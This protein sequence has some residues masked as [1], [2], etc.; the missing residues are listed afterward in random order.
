[1]AE[2]KH[3]PFLAISA[4]LMIS[5]AVAIDN[6][7]YEHPDQIG[8]N[9]QQIYTDV[10]ASVFGENRDSVLESLSSNISSSDGYA[11]LTEEQ[12][13]KTDIVSGIAVCRKYL[14][15]GECSKCVTEASKLIKAQCLNDSG[16]RIHLDGCFLRYENSSSFDWKDV[17]S[18]KAHFCASPNDS[19][20]Q[21]FSQRAEALSSQLISDAAANNSYAVG[22]SNDG[23]LYGLAQ[24]WPS[25]TTSSCQ[26]CLA[27]AQNLLLECLPQQEGR[28]LEAGCFMRYSTYEFYSDNQTSISTNP[29][30]PSGKSP[31]KRVYILLGS[32]GGSTALITAVCC[33]LLCRYIRHRNGYNRT[34]EK[35]IPKGNF[36]HGA[37]ENVPVLYDYEVLRQST[38]NF[39]RNNIL[40]KG[41][42]GEVYKGTL[43]DGTDVAVKKLN[44]RQDTTQGAE[45]FLREVKFL[46]SVRHRNLVRLRGC[47]TSGSERLLVYEFMSNNG[48][49]KH[50]FGQITNSLNWE[51]RLDIIVGT[52][53]GLS[54]LHEDSNERIIHRDI[55]CANILLDDRFHPKIGDFGMAKF[56]PE[57]ETHVS[58]RIAGTIGYT[59]P[60][61]AF[62]GQLTEKA[63]VYSYGVVVLEIMSGR[64]SLD[65]TLPDAM[66]ILLKWAWNKYQ[67][68]NALDIVDPKLEGQYPRERA[69]RVITIALLCTQ[70]SSGQ[71]PAM[72]Q[73]VSMLTTDIE[74]RVQPTEP[75]FVA[76]IP[77]RPASSFTT[78]NSESSTSVAAS[79]QSSGS[80]SVAAS[81]QSSGSFAL[82]IFRG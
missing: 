21:K 49:H 13:G 25:L 38:G 67:Q 56:F 58:T 60:E 61:Y 40:G 66:H 1:M 15:P 14:T 69:L 35:A 68:G 2:V 62:Y 42:F 80:T 23:S 41:G 18:G 63:D 5:M 45:E 30:P 20:P 51:N 9:N 73:V 55:K 81:H 71:R 8:C 29:T 28:G 7:Q 78:A 75:T 53:R 16:G 3:F 65:I 24:C 64:K 32:I 34:D 79:H 70:G 4:A 10:N 26:T 77:A 31:S 46:T 74:I 47:C 76:A 17:D 50:L 52:A 19:D 33:V 37:D 27:A 54:Y 57:G 59:A 12:H 11:A 44:G 22:R 48:L 39:H 36:E 82:S 43:P 6:P 72:S